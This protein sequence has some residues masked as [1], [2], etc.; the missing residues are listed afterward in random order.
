MG[1][2]ADFFRGAA[3]WSAFSDFVDFFGKGGRTNVLRAVHARDI[4]AAIKLGFMNTANGI[5]KEVAYCVIDICGA[6]KGSEA[7]PGRREPA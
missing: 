5:V 1:A 6:C 3:H 2:Y 7:R 4:A